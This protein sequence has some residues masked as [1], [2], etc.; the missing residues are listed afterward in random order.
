MSWHIPCLDNFLQRQLRR[1]RHAIV[2]EMD[3]HRN[4]ERGFEFRPTFVGRP[5]PVRVAPSITRASQSPPFLNI[6]ELRKLAFECREKRKLPVPMS[7]F[8]S[9]RRRHTR[10]DC[11]WSSDVCSSDL[12]L[13]FSKMCFAFAGFELAPIVSEEIVEPRR[14]IPRAIFLSAISIAFVYLAGTLALLVA[15]R[16]SV[17]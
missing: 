10:F 9:S 11:D 3:L 15:D 6:Y 7:F 13:A 4:I 8:F 12:V 16:K 14:T 2:L 1:N 5:Q 17:V